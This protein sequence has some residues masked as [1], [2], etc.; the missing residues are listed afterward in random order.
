MRSEPTE[1][2]GNE[3]ESLGKF[4]ADFVNDMIDDWLNDLIYFIYKSD[5]IKQKYVAVLE[6][7]LEEL[8]RDEA[9]DD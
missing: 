2:Q 1:L 9:I 8:N 3:A 5:H 7:V 6:P 4:D